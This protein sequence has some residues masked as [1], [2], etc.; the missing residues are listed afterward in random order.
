MHIPGNPQKSQMV[1][2]EMRLK[3]HCRDASSNGGV[4]ACSVAQNSIQ[5]PCIQADI[6]PT[7]MDPK[8][9]LG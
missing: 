6:V 5:G 8:S 3:A 2:N 9:S 4:D 1:E 7:L